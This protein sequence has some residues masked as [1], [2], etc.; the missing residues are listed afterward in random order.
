MLLGM[1]VVTVVASIAVVVNDCT[2]WAGAVFTELSED[3]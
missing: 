1:V 2:P 3:A